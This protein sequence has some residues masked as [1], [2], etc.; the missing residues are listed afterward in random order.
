ATGIVLLQVSANPYV[1]LLGRAEHASSRLN[2]AQA[3]NS[4]GTTIG[5]LL[6][7]TLVLA[8]TGAHEAW[9]LEGLYASLAL[10]L[11]LISF[12]I[13]AVHLP[14]ILPVQYE[15]LQIQIVKHA[16]ETTQYQLSHFLKTRLH[17]VWRFPHLF[18]GV[19]AIFFYVGGEVAIGSMLV[20]YLSNP[21]I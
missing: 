15:N 8:T 12:G 6:G 18:Y 9:G 4:L 3:F 13:R 2:L 11:I 17:R 21:A 19:W 16:E 20:N 14:E 7:S 1:A 10:L 5:P